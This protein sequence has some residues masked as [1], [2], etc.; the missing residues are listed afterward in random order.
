[1]KNWMIWI[2]VALMGVLAV[3]FA[4]MFAMQVRSYN[5]LNSAA[6]AQ[7]LQQNNQ[8][9]DLNASLD[10]VNTDLL[11]AK[12]DISTATSALDAA[13]A[14][15][16]TANNELDSVKAELDTAKADLETAKADLEKA[17]A[18]LKKPHTSVLINLELGTIVDAAV[19]ETMSL[20]DCFISVPIVKD[21]A[22][23]NR[24]N[25]KSWVDNNDIALSELRY[26]KLLHYNFNGEVQVGELI[27]NVALV[28]DYREIFTEL[29]KA[30][31]QIF[32]M[33]L[34][35]NYWADTP[36]QSDWQS[37][38]VN[39][40]SAFCY[41][42]SSVGNKLS[43]HAFGRAIDINPMQNPYVTLKNGKK[44]CEHENAMDFIDRADPKDHMITHDDLCYK[45]FIEHGFTWGGDWSNPLDY[46][47]FEKEV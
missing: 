13:N 14:A 37:I 29:L 2:I 28:Q 9:D 36:A 21:D 18:E 25:G 15:L 17:N 1:M 20:D 11:A 10:K 30:K 46:Q 5:Q 24:I 19:F 8:I 44:S 12:T 34:I 27:A 39:N 35:D 26:I 31:Y 45:L 38:D 41:R 42:K 22:V 40:T 43:N 47:H 4:F 33:F 3:F 16:S 6:E 7:N 32:S 23:F